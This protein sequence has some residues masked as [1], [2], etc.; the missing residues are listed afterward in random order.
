MFYHSRT[1]NLGKYSRFELSDADSEDGYWASD[2]RSDRSL[3]V[4]A[5]VACGRAVGNQYV[6]VGRFPRNNYVRTVRNK[7]GQ[8]EDSLDVFEK[9]EI[10]GPMLATN[11][12]S[13]LRMKLYLVKNDNSGPTELPFRQTIRLLG[14][15]RTTR[16]TRSPE[17]GFYGIFRRGSELA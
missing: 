6:S 8:A 15:A 16:F 13:Y 2:C 1:C 10:A 4:F 14:V 9:N 11:G 12:E 17:R 3:M 5:S 7:W